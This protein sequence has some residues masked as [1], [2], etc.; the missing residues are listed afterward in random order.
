VVA[1][2]GG[3]RVDCEGGP[4]ECCRFGNR[5]NVRRHCRRGMR[6]R[7]KLGDSIVEPE[8]SGMPELGSLTTMRRLGRFPALPF[9]L[10]VEP[11]R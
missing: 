6:G 7:V 9:P 2:A 4:D 5:R 10:R 3:V 8:V 1:E 11:R